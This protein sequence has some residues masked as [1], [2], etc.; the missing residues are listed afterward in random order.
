MILRSDFLY[1]PKKET[2]PAMVEE[3]KRAATFS[4][5]DD[6]DI[7][8]WEEDDQYLK[9]PRAIPVDAP[10]RDLTSTSEY[11]DIRYKGVKKQKLKPFQ[12]FAIYDTIASL[13]VLQGGV[14]VCRTGGGKTVCA[15]NI[16]S[17]LKQRTLILVDQMDLMAQWVLR[18]A[19][20]L[21]GDFKVAYLYGADKRSWKKADIVIATLQTISKGMPDSFKDRFGLVVYDEVHVMAAPTFAKGGSAIRARYRL[22]LTA[23][24]YRGD[25]LE[26]L[27]FANIGPIV[28]KVPKSEVDR[29]G[30]TIDPD[31]FVLPTDYLAVSVDDKRMSP[32]KYAKA[33]VVPMMR[34]FNKRHKRW[35]SIVNSA[36]LMTMCAT[37]PKHYQPIFS[38]ICAAV[39]KGRKVLLISDRNEQLRILHKLCQ[40]AKI[41]SSVLT[42]DIKKLGKRIEALKAQV[43]LSNF[44]LTQKGL[45]CPELDVLMFGS[46]RKGRTSIEQAAGRV[47]RN[48]IGKRKP[49]I[50][51]FEPKCFVMESQV[52]DLLG[53]LH[54]L[55]CKVIEPGFGRKNDLRWR[56]NRDSKG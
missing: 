44:T 19:Q 30:V 36:K 39:S 6:E 28:H 21:E 53:I 33:A 18:I 17:K 2:S 8:A 9:I 38:E 3:Y 27:F 55:G 48:Y 4:S 24:P 5:K 26:D 11:V 50:L 47:S 23:T 45:D 32:T 42:G 16:M 25:G 13:F 51:V 35:E 46:L 12:T 10:I 37:S 1:I 54:N 7:I 34:K 52:N 56:K 20:F 29:L 49:L 22:G 43:I 31:V 41:D 40:E 14:L 15:L